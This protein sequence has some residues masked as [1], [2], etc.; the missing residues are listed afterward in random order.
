MCIHVSHPHL[1]LRFI[2]DDMLQGVFTED[3]RYQ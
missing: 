3:G 2:V 1:F